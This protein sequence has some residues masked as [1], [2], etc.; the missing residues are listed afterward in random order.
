MK[1]YFFAVLMLLFTISTFAQEGT[2]NLG[3]TLGFEESVERYRATSSDTKLSKGVTDGLKVGLI[4]ETSLVKGF[5]VAM[6]LNYGFGADVNDFE[7]KISGMGAYKEKVDH[8]YHYLEIPVDWQYKFTIAKQ[9]YLTLYTGPTLQVG[10]AN[11]YRTR[12]KLGDTL[13]DDVRTDVY[14]IDDDHDGKLDY[15]RVNVTWGIGLGF[16]Y[17][18]YFIRG[19][20]D[21]GIMPLYHDRF[22]NISSDE[23]SGW[24]RKGRLDQWQI[25]LGVYFWQFKN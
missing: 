3:V 10:L 17:K 21:M 4:Y 13:I 8:Y 9:T 1:K 11:S 15:N 14:K 25:K 24:N 5:G 23:T 19:G 22:Y 20:Y 12:T 16:Q 18:Q 7:A 6:G 2:S